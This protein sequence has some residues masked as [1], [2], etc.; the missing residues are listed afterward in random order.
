MECKNY[1]YREQDFDMCKNCKHAEEDEDYYHVYLMCNLNDSMGE[2]SES[3]ICDK[4]ER[5]N[6]A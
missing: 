1:N 2:C 3:Y 4:Y 5:N 6:N